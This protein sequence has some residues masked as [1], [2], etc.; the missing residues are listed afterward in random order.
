M[1]L[2]LPAITSLLLALPL[3]AQ[4]TYTGHLR[5]AKP[6]KGTVVIVQSD[7]I[8]QVVNNRQTPAHPATD[9]KKGGKASTTTT[10]PAKP[11]HAAQKSPTEPTRKPATDTSSAAHHTT[12]AGAGHTAATPRHYAERARHK[13]RGFRICIFTG[14]NSRADKMKAAEMGQKCRQKFPELATYPSFQSPRWV[15]HVGD[16]R[17]RQE[18]QKYVNLIRKA[19]LSYEVRIVSSEVNVP[20]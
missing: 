10:S 17:T 13:A 1:K 15:T 18:A 2:L 16:F 19:R 7:A 20:F 14:G 4:T 12:S 8:E 5:A 11:E 6:G 3:H 9:G